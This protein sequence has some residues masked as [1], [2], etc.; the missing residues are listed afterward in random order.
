MLETLPP[1]VAKSRRSAAGDAVDGGLADSQEVVAVGKADLIEAWSAVDRLVVSLATIGRCYG[2]PCGK[3]WDEQQHQDMLQALDHCFSPDLYQHLRRA[4]RALTKYVPRDEAI[5]LAE[6][7]IDYWE[8]DE[9]DKHGRR[10]ADD[11]RREWD[12]LEAVRRSQPSDIA[13]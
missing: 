5:D 9:Y 4:R 13:E 7:E 12:R 6:N 10:T 3:P 1:A 2:Q 8:W 11:R